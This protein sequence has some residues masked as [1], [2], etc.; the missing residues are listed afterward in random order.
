M[1][2]SS[3]Q[4]YRSQSQALIRK[5]LKPRSAER[6]KRSLLNLL[7]GYWVLR[8]TAPSPSSSRYHPLIYGIVGGHIDVI[9]LLLDQAPDINARA[10][11]GITALHLAILCTSEA[12]VRL[13]LDH[14]ADPNAMDLLGA[15]PFL[16]ARKLGNEALVQLLLQRGAD[17]SITPTTS[18]RHPIDIAFLKR[19]LGYRPT[20]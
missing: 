11:G 12:V 16:Y 17:S 9:T 2:K 4:A 18:T 19:L 5:L 13:L 14:K 6:V 10:R 20:L 7:T 8:W 1:R 15:T 3:N